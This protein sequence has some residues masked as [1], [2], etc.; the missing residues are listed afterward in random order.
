MKHTL[1]IDFYKDDQVDDQSIEKLTTFINQWN[2]VHKSQFVDIIGTGW[3][4]LLEKE[5][6]AKELAHL[7]KEINHLK[8]EHDIVWEKY[9]DK[10]Y[11]QSDFNNADWI[12]LFGKGVPEEFFL[13][14][15]KAMSNPKKCL[16]CGSQRDN[17]RE[18]IEPFIID[19][20]YLY[21][22][23]K[24]NIYQHSWDIVNSTYGLLVSKRVIEIFENYKVKGYILKEV[25]SKQ[26]GTVS[27]VMFQLYAQKAIIV[28][29]LEHTT[30][31]G[32]GVC[33]SCGKYHGQIESELFIRSEWIGDDEIFTT[34]PSKRDKFHF[35][36]RIYHLLKSHKINGIHPASIAFTCHK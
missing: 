18:Q 7:L 15:R 11:E 23:Q 21:K 6:D 4:I 26:T 8:K 19:E 28:P 30:I 16:V 27:K 25:I 33:P 10:L 31:T 32:K 9:E 22:D 17:S 12:L 20:N 13:N 34:A 24:G 3:N 1:Q 5:K 29:C 14:E 2:N 36:N 35:S